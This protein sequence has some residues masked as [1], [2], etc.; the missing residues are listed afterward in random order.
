MENNK[1]SFEHDIVAELMDRQ[2]KSN[3]I[4]LFNL[5]KKEKDCDLEKL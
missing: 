4:I 5:L 1:S 2:L 3:N